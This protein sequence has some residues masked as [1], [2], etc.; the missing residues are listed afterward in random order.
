VTV[1]HAAMAA[2]HCGEEK[3]DQHPPDDLKREHG[4]L[5]QTSIWLA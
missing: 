3:S 4:C 5:P 1:G 2:D